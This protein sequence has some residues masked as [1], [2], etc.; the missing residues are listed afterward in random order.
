MAI[1][2]HKYH[3]TFTED[4]DTYPSVDREINFSDSS[5]SVDD[6]D[7]I[8]ITPGSGD[9]WNLDTPIKIF[10]SSESISGIAPN[11]RRARY[12]LIEVTSPVYLWFENDPGTPPITS[13]PV[14]VERM[15]VIEG[16]PV[17]CVQKIWAINPSRTSDTNPV[18]VEIK[19]YY[20]LVNLPA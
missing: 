13:I 9:T 3:V 7:R 8:F 14:R 12:L 1:V 19:L 4:T 20:T 6:K 16:P 11:G 2:N 18:T 17:G 15:M 10:D 5:S